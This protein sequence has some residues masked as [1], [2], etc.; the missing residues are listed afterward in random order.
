MILD[1]WSMTQRHV[2]IRLPKTATKGFLSLLPPH[3]T[4]H[5]PIL[6][7]L[8]AA[9]DYTYPTE[10][11]VLPSTEELSMLSKLPESRCNAKD[12]HFLSDI[13]FSAY[14]P[15]ETINQWLRLLEHLRP[16]LVQ[17]VSI[18]STFEG[19]EILGIRIHGDKPRRV[20]GSTDNIRTVTPGMVLHGAQHAREW[21]SVSTVCYI[22]YRL[23]ADYYSDESTRRIVDEFEWRLTPN[24]PP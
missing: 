20:P 12:L 19:R 22:A 24:I 6:T 7:N 8:R 3:L 16:E 21:I 17:L 10:R 14:Q 5:E 9:V 4:E 18:G 1:I 13:F 2:D 11:T 15:Y 23:L